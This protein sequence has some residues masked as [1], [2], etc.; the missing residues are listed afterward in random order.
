MKVLLINGFNYE[1]IKIKKI[2]ELV[3]R[4]FKNIEIIYMRDKEIKNCLG[5]FKCWI[6]TPGICIT[7]DYGRDL[8]YNIINSDVVILFTPITFGG[9]SSQIKKGLDRII[10]LVSPFFTNIDGETHHRKRYDNYPIYSSIGILPYPN[11]S[12]ELIFRKL[13]QR[14][15][16][17][18]YTISPKEREIVSIIYE[19]DNNDIITKKLDLM[20]SMIMQRVTK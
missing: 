5:C 1:D 9:Y 15:S 8:A 2:E 13:V 3:S 14:N 19:N 12:Q 16:I 6:K 18:F 11:A 10:S 4:Q 20:Y 7:D 17:N